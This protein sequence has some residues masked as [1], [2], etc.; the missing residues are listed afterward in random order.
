MKFK[1]LGVVLA[2]IVP[3]AGLAG[4]PH[5]RIPGSG[6]VVDPRRL[7]KLP[8]GGFSAEEA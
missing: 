5:Q 8:A 6:L 7:F 2:M 4:E 1:L 3:G